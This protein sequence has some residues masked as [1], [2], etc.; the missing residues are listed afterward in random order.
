MVL[1]WVDI[2]GR[3]GLELTEAD[4]EKEEER[5]ER[6]RRF[7]GSDMR[8]MKVGSWRSASHVT[9]ARVIL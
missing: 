9:S 4:K 1:E 8:S 5:I 6:V 3:G 7:S 2:K